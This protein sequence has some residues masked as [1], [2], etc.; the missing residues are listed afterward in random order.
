MKST[1]SSRDSATELRSEIDDLT[2]RMTRAARKLD[3]T[4]VVSDVA[5]MIGGVSSLTYSATLTRSGA[6]PTEV[7]VKVAPRGLPATANRDVLRQA[8]ILNA[9]SDALSVRVP[10]VLLQD[11]GD[12]PE[13]PPW[14]AMN[15]VAGDNFEP[16]Q[17][18]T[19]QP[20]PAAEVAA[21]CSSGLAMLADL[22]QVDPA[23][24]G[25][26]HEIPVSLDDEVLRWARIY[27]TVPAELRGGVDRV[28]ARL[29]ATL[30]N[31]MP[32]VIVHGD[33]RLG[34]MLASDGRVHAVI[35]WEIW[36]LGD[37][38]LDLAWY[39]L[40]CDARSQ[41]TAVQQAIGFPSAESL[42]ADYEVS[43]G[44]L[45]VADLGWFQALCSFKAGAIVAQIIKHN[46]RS[47]T[48]NP[49]VQRWDPDVPV[50]FV[51]DALAKFDQSDGGRE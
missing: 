43:S 49:R 48:P 6:E 38:R 29:L 22:Q 9:L 42:V 46:R 21:R 33:Y 20:L 17:D 10:T 27:E 8:R 37:P 45:H 19:G 28:Q 15:R 30:P 51:A 32:P 11:A 50:R 35:D 41:H 40:N 7:V 12:P 13:T 1:T 39:L 5:A 3:P 18:E 47:A 26:G 4:C 25:L 23:L 2:D 44:I 24:V 14:F 31:P 34:N 16:I 36:T